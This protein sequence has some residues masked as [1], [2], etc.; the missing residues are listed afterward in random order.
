MNDAR[1]TATTPVDFEKFQKTP[2]F[3]KLRRTQRSFVFPMAAFFL[4]W[5]LAY[6]IV[7]ATLPEFM[8]IPVFGNINAGILIGLAQFVTTFVI[9]M[10]YVHFANTRLDTEASE[11]RAELEAIEAGKVHQ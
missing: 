8:A 10:W 7:A 11:L 9:T 1:P 2:K 6:V 5:Y 4:L 3:Q